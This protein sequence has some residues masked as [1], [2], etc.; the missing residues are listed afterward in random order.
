M[1]TI[2]YK[3]LQEAAVLSLG[4][5]LVA[6]FI[7]WGVP[8][9]GQR[10][11]LFVF[12]GMG[13]LFGFMLW[14][15]IR[16]EQGVP[17]FDIGFV[18]IGITFIYSVYPLLAFMLSGYEWGPLTDNRFRTIKP[19]PEVLGKFALHNLVYLFGLIAGYLALRFKKIP[20]RTV[21]LPIN[22][23][24]GT[25]YLFVIIY[26]LSTLYFKLLGYFSGEVP[27]LILQINHNLAS[28]KFV[29]SVALICYAFSRWNNLW[30]RGAFFLY[31]FYRAYLMVSLSSGRTWFFLT[32]L[33]S[34]MFYHRQ[35]KELTLGK[36]VAGFIVV[37]TS[38]II[39]GFY[40]VGLLHY[41]G[42][43]SMWTASNEFT[44]LLG[45]AFDIYWRKEV[46]GSI[47]EIP[48]QLYFNDI[49]LLIP[50]QLLPFVKMDTS[51]WYLDVIG[52]RGTGVGM[53]FGVISQG[54]IGGGMI[55]L[56]L[57]GIFLGGLAALLHNWYLKNS[58][59][60]L[61]N[62]AYVFI[63]VR[64]YYTYRAGTGYIFYDILYQLLPTYLL[65]TLV[66]DFLWPKKKQRRMI[67][68]SA[69]Y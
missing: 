57:R 51:Q 48:F 56:L 49:I 33:A 65:V 28:I 47:G 61:A 15:L 32:L 22:I 58:Q 1:K 46:L 26:G 36:A 29:C 8:D 59:S 4:C 38:F 42:K 18:L 13:S 17:L 39:M 19:T 43:Y 53:M 37:A 5:I 62:V 30:Y 9:T 52:L 41:V 20:L 67:G 54:V 25:V 66:R 24:K 50:S 27:Y 40:K 44:S 16:L 2:K 64:I 45:T 23:D 21:R 11:F 12:L 34:L 68:Y 31:L 55:E 69:S 14:G 60:F 35:V 63:A 6:F 3:Y 7:L 10:L